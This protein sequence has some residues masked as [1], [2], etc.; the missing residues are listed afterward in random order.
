M[1]DHGAGALGG[2]T[3]LKH[4][5]RLS[6]PA[7]RLRWKAH[8]RACAAGHRCTGTVPALDNRSAFATDDR[9]VRLPTR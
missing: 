9:D 7:L 2:E 6:A 3:Y 4:G 5:G 1:A 8:G